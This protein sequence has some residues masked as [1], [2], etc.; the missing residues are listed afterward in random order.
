M[1]TSIFAAD[2]DEKALVYME[3]LPV[4]CLLLL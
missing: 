4:C 3:N 1:K 2:V